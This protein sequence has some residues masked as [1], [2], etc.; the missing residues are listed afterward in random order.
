M[1]VSLSLWKILRFPI[2]L[3]A[4]TG[5]E[6][7]QQCNHESDSQKRKTMQSGGEAA[8]TSYSQGILAVGTALLEKRR[9]HIGLYVSNVF[10]L[11]V[12]VQVWLTFATLMD[13]W[14][15]SPTIMA[16]LKRK[17]AT[18]NPQVCQIHLNCPCSWLRRSLILTNNTG[19]TRQNS[20]NSRRS[21]NENLGCD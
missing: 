8:W 10:C 2:M 11:C 19:A 12:P 1:A 20:D 21:G 4:L 9:N 17:L 6:H 5:P 15:T 18:I 3:A 13:S 7:W 16:T 14:S